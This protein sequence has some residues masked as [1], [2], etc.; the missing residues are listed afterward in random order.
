LLNDHLEANGEQMEAKYG[1]APK[2]A[3]KKTTKM[4]KLTKKSESIYLKR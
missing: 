1:N 4:K 3:R 2:L